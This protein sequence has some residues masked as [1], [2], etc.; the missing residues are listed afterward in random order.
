MQH[1]AAHTGV[2]QDELI[3][4]IYCGNESS[5]FLLYLDDGETFDYQNGKST[6]RLIK[7]FGS[8]NKISHFQQAKVTLPHLTPKSRLFFMVHLQIKFQ[9]MVALSHLLTIFIHSFHPLKS[10]IPLM[11]P[12]LW[13]KKM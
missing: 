9:L 6:T 7:M 4:H 12:I 11:N 2:K 10:M 5:D 3:L 13:V 1:S 8:E